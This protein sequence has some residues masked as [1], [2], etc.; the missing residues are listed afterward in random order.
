MNYR[1]PTVRSCEGIARK[2]ARQAEPPAPPRKTEDRPGRAHLEAQRTRRLDR[3]VLDPEEAARS[4]HHRDVAGLERVEGQ[5]AK[6]ERRVEDLGLERREQEARRA[7]LETQALAAQER[8][9][10]LRIAPASA[11]ALGAEAVGKARALDLLQPARCGL[12]R[13]GTHLAQHQLEA[14]GAEVSG[15]QLVRVARRF[16][17]AR[18]PQ[19]ER[20]RR[21]GIELR[22]REPLA[23]HGVAIL[24]PRIAHV[25]RRHPGGARQLAC[26]LLGGAQA[27]L[28]PQEGVAAV[29]GRGVERHLVHHEVLGRGAQHGHRLRRATERATRPPARTRR[30]GPASGR[31]VAAPPGAR[32]SGSPCARRSRNPATRRR[33]D[34]E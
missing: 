10:E 27:L 18:T 17:H 2:R 6:G 3:G 16:E 19:L 23:R 13:L 24:A 20:E 12:R 4:M 31:G 26:H 29:S 1:A 22:H 15:P 9:A 28:D 33:A 5:P 7:T 25:A 11:E 30:D 21:L 14:V 32:A 8:A 34:T